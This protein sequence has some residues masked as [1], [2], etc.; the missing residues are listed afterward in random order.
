[1]EKHLVRLL[2]GLY[3]RRLRRKYG[4]EMEDFLSF[5]LA[6]ARGTGSRWAVARAWGR[7][8]KD[9][10][11]TVALEPHG[12]PGKNEPRRER[13]AGVG[14][15]VQDVRYAVRRLART[16]VFSLGALAILAIAI[17]ANTAVFAVVN[18]MLLAPPPFE[19]P[20][21]VVNIYQDSDD[22]E[23]SSSSYP[24][25][26]DMAGLEGVF[27]SV[28]AT[29]P[30]GATLDSGDGSWPVAIEYTTS[31]FLETIG[32][33]PARGRWFDARMDQV[34][35]GN[36]AVV[37]DHAWRHRFGADPGIVGRTLRIN[38]QPVTVIGVGPSGL[39]GIGGFVVTDFWLSVSSVGIGGEFRISNLD[40]REDHWYD[41]RARLA[42]GVTVAQAQGAMDALARR[43]AEAFPELNEGRGI[44]V[45]STT[46]IRL[47]PEVDGDLYPV[48]GILLTIVILVLILASSNL[49]SLLLVRGVSR[50]P[51]VAVRRAMG[52]APSRVARLFLS[53][54][55]ILSVAGGVLGVFLAQ[56]L[57]G[58][59]G[60]IP[61]PG[62]LSGA[63][64]LAIDLRVLLFSAIL[65]LV[66]G[67]F[68]GWAP[69]MQSLKANLSG[70]LREDRRAAGGGRRLSLL[71]NLMVSVQ[72]AVSLVLVVGA[73]VMV[74]SLSSYHD[75]DVGVEV[76]RLAYLQTDFLQAGIQAEERGVFLRQITE[77]IEALPGVDQV[78]LTSRL[79]LQGGGTTTTVIEGY[80]PAAGT[81]SVELA[82]SLVTPGYFET[83]GME[84]VE[85]RGYLP[86]DQVS[87]ERLVVVN[88]AAT[89]FWGG[90]S[91]VGKRIRP[92]SSPD[93]WVHVMGVVS[94]TK[95]RSLAEPETP[96]LYYVM[97]EAGVNAPSV[98][99][100]TST[101]PARLL[102]GLR[103]QLMRVNPSLP[104]VR[105]STM[106]SH[107]GQ[108]LVA[109]RVS[110]ALLGLFS[111]LALLLAAVGIYTI[112]SFSVAGRMPEI[113]IRVALG[114]VGSRVVWMVVGEVAVT[115]AV[116]LAVGSGLVAL[117]SARVQSVL[118]GAEILSLGTLLP[119]LA[120]MAGAVALAS[121]LP[122][123]RAARADPVEA[124]RAP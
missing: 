53:E 82:W 1:M 75:V 21:E 54:A 59:I 49:G 6:R 89:R 5:R 79:P 26:R 13:K 35:A 56:W 106:E 73:G 72:V 91:A 50:T 37:S 24:A 65:M 30:D 74:R 77:G 114:A 76:E 96:V 15:L 103:E 69:A 47:H 113:G 32:R 29:S 88:E 70:A 51:E 84:V 20:E 68:F 45:F 94:D 52:A 83:V 109:P 7:A 16:P 108:A 120:I 40:R 22:G 23:P 87:N 39:N 38:G 92:Q 86:E 19:R 112:V 33:N 67:L 93:G 48:A 123:R 122:A 9:L 42:E 102:G 124:L 78:A 85:G 58:L 110:A 55:L 66:T 41:V 62:P 71:R 44:T 119:A 46:D 111:L 18:Q 64:D 81:G 28:A 90:E 107:V 95:V 57:L 27:Q 61:L 4:T 99:V 121:Y 10:A 98:V 63:L 8:M 117:A 11:V 12:R 100:R 60:L 3:P 118:Y 31:S 36:F 34:G 25:Y 105:L 14:A 2:L 43:L 97:S 80:G 101:D 116:G 104:A 17:G 115:V